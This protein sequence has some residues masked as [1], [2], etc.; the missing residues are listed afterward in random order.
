MSSD[1]VRFWQGE[2]HNNQ[3]KKPQLKTRVVSPSLTPPSLLFLSLYLTLIANKICIIYFS[4]CLICTSIQAEASLTDQILTQGWITSLGRA[5]T[6]WAAPIRPHQAAASKSIL[7]PRGNTVSCGAWDLG[8]DLPL[9]QL[10]KEVHFSWL[11]NKSTNNS[12]GPRKEAM[13]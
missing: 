4:I 10:R 1:W 5:G 2:I 9:F 6:P 12:V 7:Q 11:R 13:L 3:P 8:W